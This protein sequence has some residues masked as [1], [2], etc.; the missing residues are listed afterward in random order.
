[1]HYI[2]TPFYL[3]P[4]FDYK[5]LVFWHMYEQN[6]F[7]GKRLWVGPSDLKMVP[8]Q[9]SFGITTVAVRKH[10]GTFLSYKMKPQEM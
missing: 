7:N 2:P 4:N 10:T 3:Y 5:S 9:I 8:T 6:N 1:M